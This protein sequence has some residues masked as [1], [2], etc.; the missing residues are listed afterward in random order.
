MATQLPAFLNHELCRVNKLL[1]R[2]GFA[3]ALSIGE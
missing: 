2:A 1:L 3:A